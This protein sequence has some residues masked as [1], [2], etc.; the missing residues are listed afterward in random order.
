MNKQIHIIRF[1]VLIL[2]FSLFASGSKLFAQENIL[3]SNYNQNKVFL[4]PAFSG[5]KPFMELAM[6]YHKQWT[7][8]DGAP[9]SAILSAHTPLNKSQVGIGAM[10][11]SN[12]IGILNENGLFA[13][14]AY[15]I[16][17]AKER[18]FSFGFQAGLVSKEVRWS[19]VKTYDPNFNGDDPSIPNM[20][21]SSIAPNFGLGFY[22]KTPQFHLGFSAP[23]LLQNAYPHEK[24]LSKNINFEFND[25]YF[26]LN[27]G[28][29]LKL[30]SNIQ[31]I[32]SVLLYS[33]LNTNT[34][35]S[36]NLNFK[37]QNG[38]S[39]GGSYRSGNYWSLMMGYEFDSK[40]GIS[41]SYE[42]SLDKLKRGDHTSHEIFIN[43]KI[44]FK[45]SSYT[46]PRLF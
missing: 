14:Y 22:Y 42:N 8:V 43:Y 26:Y 38:I 19:E 28:I 5:S 1:F 20:N 46:S 30:N 37:H 18:I 10:L 33:S 4:N 24:S 34:N 36:F 27:S 23:R 31:F 15:K 29:L 6:G 35:Y 39:T 9:K 2:L 13:N 12:K 11:Y 41:Y 3:F 7:G 21:I 16:D 25:I 44:S 40:I 32:P 17:M 45:K